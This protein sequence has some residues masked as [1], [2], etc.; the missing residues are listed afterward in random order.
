[1]RVM[2]F[3]YGN[4]DSEAGKLPSQKL[5]DDMGH[6][7]EEL[8]KAGVMLAGEGLYPSSKGARIVHKRG[9]MTVVD[10]PFAEAKELVVGYWIWQVRDLDEAIA[11]AKRIPGGDEYDEGTIEIR[12]I[13]ELADFDQAMQA[14]A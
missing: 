14:Q 11:W 7:N 8:V 9:T 6:F 12:P 13:F 4:E 10:G 5:V 1:M 2:V 3:I